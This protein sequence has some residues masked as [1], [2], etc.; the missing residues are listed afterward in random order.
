MDFINCKNCERQTVVIDECFCAGCG[1]MVCLHCG[2]TDSAACA[3]VCSWAATG[4][5]SNCAEEVFGMQTNALL[6]GMKL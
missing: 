1:E 5:C 4:V 2:C 3:E 6:S